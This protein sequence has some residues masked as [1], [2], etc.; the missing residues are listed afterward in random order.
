MW[1]IHKECRWEICKECMREICKQCMWEIYKELHVRKEC[2]WEITTNA[3]EKCK[4]NAFEKY[5]K[6]AHENMTIMHVE[7]VGR[8]RLRNIRGMNVRT[9]GMMHV[10]LTRSIHMWSIRIMHVRN[11]NVWCERAGERQKVRLQNSKRKLTTNDVRSFREGDGRNL[12]LW[13]YILMWRPLPIFIH[14]C[15]IFLTFEIAASSA[16]TF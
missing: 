10:R 6:S 4:K 11:K 16:N 14:C 12:Q 8:M 3:C 7:N 2:M 9:I 13:N 15:I 1:E 5:I